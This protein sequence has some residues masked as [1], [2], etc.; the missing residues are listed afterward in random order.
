MGSKLERLVLRRTPPLTSEHIQEFPHRLLDIILQAVNI[1]RT[2]RLSRA[3]FHVV[4]NPF[5]PRGSGR[6]FTFDGSS[7]ELPVDFSPPG[8]DPEPVVDLVIVPGLF[9]AGNLEGRN[10]DR[11]SEALHGIGRD[12]PKQGCG[13]QIQ[14][15]IFKA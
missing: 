7:M 13:Y 1:D 5:D 11:E 6:N 3:F 12:P 2:L 14:N 15:C 4:L 10:Y 9:K 8:S